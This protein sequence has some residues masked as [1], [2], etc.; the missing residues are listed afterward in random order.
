MEEYWKQFLKLLVVLSILLGSGDFSKMAR[1]ILKEK[2]RQ[3]VES[4]KHRGVEP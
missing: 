3:K 4:F 2:V 1:N